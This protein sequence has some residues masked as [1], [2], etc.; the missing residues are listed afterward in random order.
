MFRWNVNPL[1]D[2]FL[3]T[4]TPLGHESIANEFSVLHRNTW[5]VANMRGVHR[6]PLEHPVQ[7][8]LHKTFLQ[9]VNPVFG[10]FLPTKCPSGAKIL[11]QNVPMGRKP[12]I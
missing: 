3:F 2:F 4:N 6:V 10:F 1:F 7:N 11:A 12:F 9:N 8:S 5:W